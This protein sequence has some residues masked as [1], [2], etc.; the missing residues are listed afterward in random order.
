MHV[1]ECTSKNIWN[2]YVLLKE[3]T[4]FHQ[5]W[6]WGELEQQHGERVKR[7]QIKL[8]DTT[9][10]HAQVWYHRTPGNFWYAYM[11]RGPVFVGELADDHKS[12]AVQALFAQVRRHHAPMF[13][14]CEPYEVLPSGFGGE[15]ARNRL[16]QHTRMIN[17]SHPAESLL[18]DMH[19]K[20]RY[21]I[22]LARRKGVEVFID[23]KAQELGAF[24]HLLKSTAE[25][26]GFSLPP[27]KHFYDMQEVFAR[28]DSGIRM[29]LATAHVTGRAVAGVLL[30]CAG[31][32]VTYLHGASAN[33]HRSFMAPHLLHWEA[34]CFAKEKGYRFYDFWG[35]APAGSAKEAQWSGITRFKTGFGGFEVMYPEAQQCVF[36]P[37]VSKLYTLY[38]T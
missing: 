11:P 14:L 30:L 12:A 4:P 22:G 8:G 18:A 19:S 17:L 5:M 7:F 13:L 6:E 31:D 25:R 24:L 26:G 9:V 27:Q 23:D 15:I 37:F 33:E 3:N 2:E 1:V 10:G 29:V 36:R 35:V 34:M 28:Q 38:R 16:P 32:T 21:N 20:W